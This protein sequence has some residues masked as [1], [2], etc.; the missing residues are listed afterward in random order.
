MVGKIL[1]I[2]MSVHMVKIRC[3]IWERTCTIGKRFY[4]FRTIFQN[5]ETLV[6]HPLA[7][8]LFLF[9]NYKEKT[10]QK[11]RTLGSLIS[12]MVSVLTVHFLCLLHHCLSLK[13][14]LVTLVICVRYDFS[15]LH[16][17]PRTWK[18]PS[19]TWIIRNTFV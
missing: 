8:K 12:V 3:T 13:N 9:L 5:R 4:N 17:K 14:L 11:C 7:T 15:S 2:Y 16:K 19:H 1:Y 6:V 10:P 18:H